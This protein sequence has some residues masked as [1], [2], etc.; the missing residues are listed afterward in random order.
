MG[1]ASEQSERQKESDWAQGPRQTGHGQLERSQ[2]GAGLA[3]HGPA[4][5]ALPSALHA[6]LVAGEREDDQPP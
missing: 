2:G 3:P 1:G 4:A 5:L 6:C